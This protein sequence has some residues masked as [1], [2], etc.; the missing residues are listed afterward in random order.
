[1]KRLPLILLSLL[2][3]FPA[4]CHRIP[5]YEAGSGVYLKLNLMLDP[6]AEVSENIPLDNYP[7]LR[8][9]IEGKAPEMV[10]ACFYDAVNHE[11]VAEDFLP[12]EGG[13][14]NIPTGVYD[15]LV[16][17][18][19]TEV[20]QVEGTGVRA[21]GYAFTSNTGVRVKTRGTKAD[22]EGDGEDSGTVQ[23]VIYEPDHLFVG[24]I[25][26][27]VVPVRPEGKEETL[28]LETALERFVQT[29][30]LEIRHIEG[31]ERIAGAEVYLTGQAA[32]RYL[33]DGRCSNHPAALS[34]P[35]VLDAGQELLWTVFN[36]FGKFPDA[37]SDVVVDIL[38]T[39]T[40]GARVSFLYDATDQVLNPDNTAR[41]IVIDEPLV[42]PT[43]DYQGGGFE[44]VVDDWDGEE[45]DVII[46]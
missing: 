24:R 6:D 28:V 25:P 42:V 36:T 40:G 23:P 7:E 3:L 38:L 5:M 12:P 26:G 33:W 4:G 46:G 19:G 45:I 20:T 18:L 34:F 11:L 16:Y 22:E 43:D 32:S 35:L 10:R 39:T 29:W 9:K 27:A 1:M 30:S 17:S 44:P 14:I 37:Q 31:A 8:A 2:L 13:F 41:R 15:V 21:T